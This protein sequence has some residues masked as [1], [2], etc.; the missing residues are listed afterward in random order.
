MAKTPDIGRLKKQADKNTA[1][2]KTTG[3]SHFS[4]ALRAKRTDI[5]MWAD[6]GKNE[7]QILANLGGGISREELKQFLAANSITIKQFKR[8]A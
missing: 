2:E 6:Q 1:F 4:P 7:D 8:K 5:A 3:K